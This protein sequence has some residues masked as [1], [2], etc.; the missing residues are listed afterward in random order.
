MSDFQWSEVIETAMEESFYKEQ[1]RIEHEAAQDMFGMEW[2]HAMEK[3][4]DHRD[5]CTYRSVYEQ[6][7]HKAFATVFKEA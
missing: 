1:K 5:N 2:E 7:T 6:S 3:Y 4:S